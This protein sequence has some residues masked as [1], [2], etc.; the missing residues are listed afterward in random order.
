MPPKKAAEKPA[1]GGKNEEAD[2]G[3][4]IISF[5]FLL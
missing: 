4:L 5:R 1:K 3:E 2:K